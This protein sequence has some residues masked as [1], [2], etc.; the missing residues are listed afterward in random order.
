[1]IR[2]TTDTLTIETRTLRAR[3]QRG[4]LTSLRSIAGGPELL[5][6]AARLAPPLELVY[7]ASESVPL[8]SSPGTP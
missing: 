7:A 8:G 3:M 5:A 2:V 4:V 6:P 1:M